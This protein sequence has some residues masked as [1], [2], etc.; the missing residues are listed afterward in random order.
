MSIPS[1]SPALALDDP[2]GP[3]G[4][5]GPAPVPIFVLDSLGAVGGLLAS[6]SSWEDGFFSDSLR[7][8]ASSQDW[9]AEAAKVEDGWTIVKKKKSRPSAPLLKMN[10]KSCKGGNNPKG[11]M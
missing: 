7:L 10:L 6:G 8:S 4:G 9:A 11:K 2:H 3:V 5:Q 1:P